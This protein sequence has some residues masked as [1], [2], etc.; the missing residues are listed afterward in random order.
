ML[1]LAARQG[2]SA[3]VK[4]EAGDLSIDGAGQRIEI[5]RLILAG[6]ASGLTTTPRGQLD[7]SVS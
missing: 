7:L 2:Q 6:R 1:S 4:L 3:V 5:G